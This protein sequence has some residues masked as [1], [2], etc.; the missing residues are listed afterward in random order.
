MSK[1]VG[2]EMTNAYPEARSL[3]PPT[4]VPVAVVVATPA[5]RL[6]GLGGAMVRL[7]IKHQTEWALTSPKGLFVA[8]SHVGTWFTVTI[9]RWWCG[10]S[11]TFSGTH[12]THPA[13]SRFVGIWH[14]H[15]E[16]HERP[17]SLR[18]AGGSWNARRSDRHAGGAVDAAGVSTTVRVRL[19]NPPRGSGPVQFETGGDGHDRHVGRM[20]SR[21]ASERLIDLGSG[22]R[23]RCGGHVW[24]Y[25]HQTPHRP[26]EH[27]SVRDARE[28]P[29]KSNCGS[30]LC[31]H[32]HYASRDVALSLR[33][34]GK[35]Q[36]LS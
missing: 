36:R 33:P 11:S 16:S 5:G 7:Q 9:R 28:I 6:R 26:F 4:G 31:A 30:R 24:E 2:A 34:Y 15:D 17:C 3:R 12:R 14:H 22:R 29:E 20:L 25:V 35:R 10:S 23:A 32:G 8:A 1:V 19:R 18:D 27:R 13:S 21:G